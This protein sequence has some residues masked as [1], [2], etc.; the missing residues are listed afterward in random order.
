MPGPAEKGQ[1]HLPGMCFD[2]VIVHQNPCERK[3]VRSSTAHGLLLLCLVAP[4]A[5]V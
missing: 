1:W 4:I 3:L 2:F 5:S